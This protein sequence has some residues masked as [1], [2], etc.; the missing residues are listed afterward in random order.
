MCFQCVLSRI[1]VYISIEERSFEQDF[2][3]YFSVEERS[4]EEELWWE[5]LEVG[6]LSE[7]LK[8]MLYQ[9]VE[10]VCFSIEM[11]F[12]VYFSVEERSLEEELWWEELE[13]GTLSEL[14]KKM[15]YQTVEC[16][17]DARWEIRRMGQQVNLS[18]NTNFIRNLEFQ[19][20]VTFFCHSAVRL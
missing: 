6:T 12:C 13:V 7:L 10:C 4:L 16:L 15:L 14:L 9:T 5:E 2:C 20:S 3:V 17:A 8:K 18:S 11:Y 1:C 19:F